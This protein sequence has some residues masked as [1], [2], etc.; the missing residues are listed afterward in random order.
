ML[1]TE[2][3]SSGFES[4]S[5]SVAMCSVTLACV[6]QVHAY[7]EVVH[8]SNGKYVFHFQICVVNYISIK[9]GWNI[10]VVEGSVVNA[11]EADMP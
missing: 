5:Q 2:S 11:L 9:L 7:S 4:Y 6:N 10:A 8:L 1:S 3:K